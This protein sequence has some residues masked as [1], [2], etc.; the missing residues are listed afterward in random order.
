[1]L[2]GEDPD[3]GD[4]H[5][6]SSGRRVPQSGRDPGVARVRPRTGCAPADGAPRL[7]QPGEAHELDRLLRA[8]AGGDVQA[9]GLLYDR[10]VA[11]VYPLARAASPD[12]G[13]ADL[14]VERIYQDVWSCAARA[15]RPA[16]ALDLLL[17][18]VRRATTPPP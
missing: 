3:P 5:G 11:L 17:G 4:P 18:A 16:G 1:M 10:T 6:R 13:A 15:G 7:F 8:V 14:L 12:A 9:F 2:S